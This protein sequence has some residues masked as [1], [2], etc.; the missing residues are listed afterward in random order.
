MKR[1]YYIKIENM[2]SKLGIVI[3]NYNTYKLTCDLVGNCEEINVFKYIVI[4]DNA[5]DDDF[6]KFVAT[7]AENIKYIKSNTNKGYAAGN[8]IGLRFLYEHNCDIDFIANPYV[9]FEKKTIINISNFLETNPSCAVASCSR[10]YSNNGIT[11]QYWWIPTFNIALIESVYLGRRYLDRKCKRITNEAVNKIS[12]WKEVEVVGGAFW[13][14]KMDILKNMNFLDEGT[15]LWYEENILSY[16]LRD[17]G[18]KVAFLVNC[19]YVHN[20][21]NNGRG[22]PNFHLFINSKKYFCYRYLKI[23]LFQKILLGIFDF[24]GIVEEKIICYIYRK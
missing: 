5:S 17:A 13:A 2:N 12:N 3:L 23:N 19:N 8:N 1:K 4:V 15:F 16:R 21:H 20:H 11:G 6:S 10:E 14:G 18:Y 9:I 24:I 7:K 22:N